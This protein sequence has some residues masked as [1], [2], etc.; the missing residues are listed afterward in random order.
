MPLKCDTSLN[1]LK[2]INDNGK[3]TKELIVINWMSNGKSKGM[4]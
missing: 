1:Q 3:L 2:I 4:F